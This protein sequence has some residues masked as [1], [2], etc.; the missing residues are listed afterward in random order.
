MVRFIIYYYAFILIVVSLFLGF[1][2]YDERK[3]SKTFN[4]MKGLFYSILICLILLFTINVY[5]VLK[6]PS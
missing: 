2:I 3:K 1:K 4:D 5:V 6:T